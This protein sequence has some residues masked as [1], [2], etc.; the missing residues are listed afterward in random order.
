MYVYRFRYCPYYLIFIIFD[1]QQIQWIF[2]LAMSII[3]HCT[4]LTCG[5]RHKT[6]MKVLHSTELSNSF[7]IE[8]VSVQFAINGYNK[9]ACFVLLKYDEK[10]CYCWYFETW[11][12]V[13]FFIALF[14]STTYTTAYNTW[15]C[16]YVI[17]NK[18]CLE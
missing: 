3:Q 17:L 2:I 12:M 13:L 11:K 5:I 10:I 9:W 4:F 1:N 8:M 16:A 6:N 7:Q 14:E 15:T 18:H